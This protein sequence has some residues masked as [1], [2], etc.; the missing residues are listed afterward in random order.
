[1]PRFYPDSNCDLYFE[2][3]RG[4]YHDP[5]REVLRKNQL[6]NPVCWYRDPTTKDPN[7]ST[8]CVWG[9]GDNFK[10]KTEFKAEKFVRSRIR[11]DFHLP[12]AGQGG[13]WKMTRVGCGGMES[14][15]PHTWN[16]KNEW[17][18]HNQNSG[19]CRKK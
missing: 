12:T 16:L 18:R 11:S 4:N 13:L 5:G 9:A 8:M 6:K 17:L 15:H 19:A 10:K 7:R 14:L 3:S 2:C 1:M